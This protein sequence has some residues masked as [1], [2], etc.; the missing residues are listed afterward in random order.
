M[1]ARQDEFVAALRERQVEA[2]LEGRTVVVPDVVDERYDRIRDALVASGAPLRRLAPHRRTLG[3]LFRRRHAG[4]GRLVSAP[5]EATGRVFDLGFRRYEGPRE[6]RRRAILAVYTDGLRTAMGLGRGGRAKVVPWL[7][8][9]ASLIPALVLAL[10]AGAVNRAAPGFD[11]A[12]DLPSHA[13]YYAIASIVLLVFVAVIGPELF[14]PDRRN[15]TISLYLVRPLTATDYAVA[16]WAAL[17]TVIVAAAWLPQVVLL[18]G[19]VL[20]ASDPV[21]YLGDNWF[22]IPRFL[23]AGAALAFYFASLATLVASSTTRRAYAA[24]FMVGAFVVSGAVVGSVVDVL[25]LGTAR[26]LALL[27]LPDLPLYMN[28]LVFGGDPTAGT[29]AGEHLPAVIQVG[30]YLLVSCLATLLAL[31]RYRRLAT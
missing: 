1:T 2:R 10:I 12:K 17:V 23:L 5:A 4:G 25:S 16:R 24:A 21:A 13:D 20:G 28:D 27:S 7:F 15:G 31:W 18:A 11:A 19:L 14:C 26:W 22:D 9:G 6:G 8:I 3:E 30:W 29:T